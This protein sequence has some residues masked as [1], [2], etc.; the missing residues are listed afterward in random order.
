[1]SID[2]L[3]NQ[4]LG[5]TSSRRRGHTTEEQR[6]SWINPRERR[7]RPNQDLR[8]AS[9]V[10]IR[11]QDDMFLP[12]L[13]TSATLTPIFVA[14]WPEYWVDQRI[15]VL[16]K[17]NDHL[18]STVNMAKPPKMLVNHVTKQIDIVSLNR[19]NVSVFFEWS[20]SARN[21]TDTHCCWNYWKMT[22][23]SDLHC[24]NSRHRTLVYKLLSIPAQER[25]EF[26]RDVLRMHGTYIWTFQSTQIHC[27]HVKLHTFH[28]SAQC[29]TTNNQNS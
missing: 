21:L 7:Q 16:P 28:R 14:I 2:L 11:G 24:S 15:R 6:A 17:N 4:S 13:A 12:P 18:P 23:L 22:S 3:R 26:T 10:H 27:S 20:V 8:K 5:C 19:R 1:M 9:A 25:I 29:C